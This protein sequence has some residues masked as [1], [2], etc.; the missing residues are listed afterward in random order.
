MYQEFSAGLS[1]RA[2]HDS[3]YSGAVGLFQD[4]AEMKR[5]VELA[6]G[7]LEER[8]SPYRPPEMHRHLSRAQLA[9]SLSAAQRIYGGLEETAKAWRSLFE[10]VG[11]DPAETARDRVVLRF[12]PHID[13]DEP[14]PWHRHATVDFHRDT[15]GTN[16]YAQINWWAPVY[17]LSEGRTVALFPRLWDRPLANDSEQFDF[18]ATRRRLREAPESIRAVDLLPKLTGVVDAA[19]AVPVTIAPGSIIAFS[20]QHAHAAVPNHTGLTRISFDTRTLSISDHLAGIGHTTWMAV[21]GGWR[22]AFF[23]V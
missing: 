14:V 11:L 22:Q 1:P 8:F 15:W 23:A 2:F 9:E 18:A 19:L 21:R 5:I 6:R 4:L 13:P 12:Q 10:A 17:P 3:L 20:A 16:L 7:F